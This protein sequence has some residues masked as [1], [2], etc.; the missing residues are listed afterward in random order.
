MAAAVAYEVSVARI[1]S[2]ER[3]ASVVAARRQVARA[4]LRA[5]YSVAAAARALRRDHS[6]VLHLLACGGCGAP[7]TEREP[8]CGVCGTVLDGAMLA[9]RPRAMLLRELG[10]EA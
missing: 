8:V 7:R 4:L 1:F 5:G 6:T 3:S 9:A 2:A 10:V